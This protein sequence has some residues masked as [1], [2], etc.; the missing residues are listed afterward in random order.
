MGQDVERL[1]ELNRDLSIFEARLKTLFESLLGDSDLAVFNLNVKKEIEMRETTK[2]ILD[3]LVIRLAELAMEMPKTQ[4]QEK[5]LINL[6]TKYI[7][8]VCNVFGIDLLA[9]VESQK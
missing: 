6:D 7:I 3:C 4:E 5:A 8:D 1:T 9:D 2:K